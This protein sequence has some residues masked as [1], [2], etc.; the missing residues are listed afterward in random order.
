[1]YGE[2]KFIRASAAKR[3]RAMSWPRMRMVPAVG[4]SRPSSIAIVVVLPAPLP[5]SNPSVRPAPKRNPTPSTASTL[6]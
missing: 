6:S 1:M 5:P 2:E 3:S 4:I